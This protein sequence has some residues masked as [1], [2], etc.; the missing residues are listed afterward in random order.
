MSQLIEDIS[1]SIA[2]LNKM[3]HEPINEVR[4]VLGGTNL[5]SSELDGL[6]R[7]WVRDNTNRG[8]DIS[9]YSP[10]FHYSIKPLQKD[11]IGWFSNKYNSFG[12]VVCRPDS[13]DK[14]LLGGLV[15]NT[16]RVFT[17]K[18]TS[19]VNFNLEKGTYAFLDN[20]YYEDTDKIR[21]EKKTAYTKFVIDDLDLLKQSF[22]YTVQT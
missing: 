22:G 5:G 17:E 19:L 11:V 20:A 6:K 9:G 3:S 8:T 2:G 15:K 18:G 16:F 7:A 1:K 13:V 14:R 4:V 12:W 21:F 10:K